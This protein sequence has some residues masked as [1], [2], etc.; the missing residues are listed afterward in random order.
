MRGYLAARSSLASNGSGT[1]RPSQ[2]AAEALETGSGQSNYPGGGEGSHAGILTC[3]HPWAY[4]YRGAQLRDHPDRHLRRRRRPRRLPR[5]GATAPERRLEPLGAAARCCDDRARRPGPA[6]RSRVSHGARGRL[7][8]PV[9]LGRRGRPAR[10]GARPP[11]VRQGLV[12]LRASALRLARVGGE[13][14][15]GAGSSGGPLPGGARITVR[16]GRTGRGARACAWRLRLGGPADR[17]QP[18]PDHRHRRGPRRAT[19]R[20]GR[21][22]GDCGARRGAA[23]ASPGSAWRSCRLRRSRSCS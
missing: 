15:P 1:R 14:R 9:L 22:G 20:G 11:C 23:D 16:R 5:G 21:A 12:P 3:R 19:R 17:A 7:R 18:G 6:A 4:A 10:D 13:R 2:Q 8:R